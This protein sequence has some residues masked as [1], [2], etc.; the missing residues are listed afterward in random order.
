[1]MAKGPVLFDLEDK[2]PPEVTVAEAP[3]VPDTVA[4]LPDGQAMQ[5]AARLAA[6]KPSR[7]VRLFWWLLTALVGAVVSIAA[8]RFVAD[9]MA[10]YPL[11][12]LGMTILIGA[13]LI[14]LAL[15]ALRAS[16]PLR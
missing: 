16:L 5:L 1:M 3:P 8:W 9:L 12:G 11:L 7:L 6:H 14:V 10:S 13:F 2:A 15:I 4:P